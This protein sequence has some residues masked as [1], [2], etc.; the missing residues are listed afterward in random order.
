MA[1]VRYETKTVKVL[2][3]T[4]NRSIAK[5]QGKG[6]E[7]VTQDAGTARST[8]IF[9]KARRPVPAKALAIGGVAIL[10]VAGLITGSVLLFGGGG[11]QETAA[12]PASATQAS[13]TPP[14]TVTASPTADA[15]SSTVPPTTSEAA[16]ATATGP[17]VDTTVDELLDRLNSPDLGGVALGDR[18]RLT[19]ELFQNDA[20][21]VGAAGEFGVFL[22]AKGGADDLPVFVDETDA[23]AWTNGTQVSFVLEAVEVTINGELLDGF[24][25]AQTVQTI[26]E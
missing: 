14:P 10:V 1:E 20:W 9:R 19:G 26:S 3:G 22:E 5:W 25:R 7:L 24:L 2:R 15:T 13:A 11:D 21:G 17:I 4:E 12:A 16:Q 8:L 18:F 6:W 23:A